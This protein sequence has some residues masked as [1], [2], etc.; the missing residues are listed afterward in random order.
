MVYSKIV[1]FDRTEALHQNGVEFRQQFNSAIRTSPT[2]SYDNVRRCATL[3]EI[4]YRLADKLT[5]RLNEQ[6]YP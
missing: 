3:P 5:K 4:C 2:A 6:T 1:N